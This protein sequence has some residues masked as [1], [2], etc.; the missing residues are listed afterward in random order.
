MTLPISRFRGTKAFLLA[1]SFLILPV[2]G[3][4]GGGGG[5]ESYSP[6]GGD[7]APVRGIAVDPYISDAVFQE[8]SEDNVVLQESSRSDENGGFFFSRPLTPGSV[9]KT[10]PSARGIHNGLPYTGILKRKV[11]DSEVQVVSPLTTLAANG[12][13][14]GE[15]LS[16]LTTAGLPGL[17]IA[18]LTADPMAAL[19][20]APDDASALLPLQANVAVNAFFDLVGDYSADSDLV[21]AESDRLT[22]MVD[23]VRTTLDARVLDEDSPVPPSVVSEPT[24]SN[25]LQ[26]ALNVTDRVVEQKKSDASTDPVTEAEK[27]LPQ[28]P[29]LALYYFTRD[30]RGQQEIEESVESGTLPD[31]QPG[32]VPVIAPSGEIVPVSSPSPSPASAASDPASP[33]GLKAVPDVA[34][35]GVTTPG[36]RG[37]TIIRVNTLADN[38]NALTVNADGTRSGSLRAAL[39]FNG[40]RIIVFE[41][42]GRINLN[43]ELVVPHPFVTIA[44]QTAPPP[45][46]TLYGQAFRIATHDVVVQHLRIRPNNN[47][48]AQLNGPLGIQDYNNNIRNVVIDRCSLGWGADENLAIWASS[49]RTISDVT[50]SNSIIHESIR[51]SSQDSYGMIFG[52][53]VKRVATTGNL[54]ISNRT[55]NPLYKG[56][57]EAVFANNIA[58]NAALGAFVLFSDDY[59]SGGAKASV[60]NNIFKR[61]PS[62]SPS[63]MAWFSPDTAGKGFQVYQAGNIAQAADGN[64]MNLSWGSSTPSGVMVPSPPVWMEDFTPE[65]ASTL[66]STVLPKVGARAGERGTSHQDAND[67]RLIEEY[68][69]GRGSIPGEGQLYPAPSIS[70]EHRAFSLPA[71]P[72]N[73]ADDGYTEI[74]KA[75]HRMAEAVQ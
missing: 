69:T 35:F 15:I 26:A 13:S 49:G 32:T 44:G 39:N 53:G 3:C 5:E 45:G 50:I 59:R 22:E 65:S 31:A 9:L 55:R 38:N 71:G 29:E 6:V 7:A 27:L 1:L 46:I 61:G 73:L 25:Y 66:E 14:E 41:V 16:L 54:L 64:A 37:G 42:S 70:G 57:S 62:G 17:T 10:K 11:D 40:K 75:L 72:D 33:E 34:G 12:L 4:G 56:G 52:D 30:N 8:I 18:D 28:V 23:L 58:Y 43:S 24:F 74:E 68:Q 21:F 51:P 20:S 19:Q 63:E 36:G 47:T 67:A 60:V 48:T 2:F